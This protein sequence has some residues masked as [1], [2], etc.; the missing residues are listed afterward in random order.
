MNKMICFFL[1]FFMMPS[2]S[3]KNRYRRRVDLDTIKIVP[4]NQNYA[5]PKD[6]NL[7]GLTIAEVEKLYGERSYCCW[8]RRTHKNANDFYEGYEGTFHEIKDY[9]VDIIAFVWERSKTDSICMKVYF[10]IENDDTIAI[11]AIQ[12]PN[13]VLQLD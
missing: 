10:V 8:E 7:Y 1:L 11:R 2:C 5:F 9:P 13:W 3:Y 6:F 12:V 4:A